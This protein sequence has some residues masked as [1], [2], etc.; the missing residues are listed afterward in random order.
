MKTRHSVSARSNRGS[1]AH[2]GTLRQARTSPNTASVDWSQGEKS[3]RDAM[4]SQ[5]DELW[6]SWNFCDVR[7][8]STSPPLT[9]L[10]GLTKLWPEMSKRRAKS[11]E[12]PLEIHVL[13]AAYPFEGRSDWS[14]LSERR[15]ADVPSV[16]IVLVLGTP[17]QDDN[18]PVSQHIEEFDPNL[19]LIA[20]NVTL[21]QAKLGL[22]SNLR[23]PES[24]NEKD[25][26][27]TCDGSSSVTQLDKTWKKAELCKDHG[28][29]LEIVCLERYYQDVSSELPAPDA[30]L[31]FSPGFPQLMRRS[32]DI[33]LQSVL[34]QDVPVLVGDLLNADSLENLF[35]GG[36]HRVEAMPG[37]HFQVLDGSM[38]DG[39][40][41]MA[42]DAY[43]A[44]RLAAYRNPFPILIQTQEEGV[45]AKNAVLQI[46]QGRK[47][48]AEPFY[49]PTLQDVAQRQTI[50]K[51][52]RLTKVIRDAHLA[53]DIL[54]SLAI[55]TDPAYDAAMMKLY[56]SGIQEQAEAQISNTDDGQL[57]Q[58]LLNRCQKLG[59]MGGQ[60]RTTSWS[61]SDWI[62]IL[63]DLDAANTFL[64]G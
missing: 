3:W 54:R 4:S 17:W 28:N 19:S 22:A 26:K 56:M 41:L 30:V 45:I 50:L 14:L 43:R 58:E 64:S 47:A 39:M 49:R 2:D 15:P 12:K 6:T 42:M 57:K 60:R 24:G 16:R 9:T 62:F 33:V 34:S 44:K 20:T 11:A 8:I 36:T 51:Q 27:L 23:H 37:E 32:W 46:F 18:V 59:L 52:S 63:T 21:Y 10:F 48:D 38:E 35:G 29:G 13:G 55:P 1:G 61:L 5:M 31:L 7:A 53:D 25:G 40:T